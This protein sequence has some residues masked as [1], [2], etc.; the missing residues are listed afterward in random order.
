MR[1]MGRVGA[2]AGA[3]LAEEAAVSVVMLMGSRAG[4]RGAGRAPTER[5][6]R[7][8]TFLVFILEARPGSWQGSS[9]VNGSGV[10]T[11]S[12]DFQVTKKK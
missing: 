8:C 11:H 5:I 4:E 10:S 7:T 1:I 2:G 12:T 3:G 6:E 9:Q